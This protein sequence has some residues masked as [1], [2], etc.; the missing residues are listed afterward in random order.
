MDFVLDHPWMIS[1]IVVLVIA[2]ASWKS[3]LWL[4]GII[5]I[6]DDSIGA[7]TKKFVILGANRNLPDGQIIA[8]EGEAG[9]QADTLSPGLHMGPW[10]WQYMIDLVKFATIPQGSIGVVQACDGA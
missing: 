5:I 2:D 8:L 6:A 3:L 4:F 10:P 1:A 9:Y 7:V